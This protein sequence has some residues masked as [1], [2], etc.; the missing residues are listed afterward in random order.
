[1]REGC[2]L[3]NY[4]RQSAQEALDS[5][6]QAFRIAE[7]VLL[8]A[9]V[10]LDA[11]YVSHALEPVQVPAQ[12]TVDAYLPRYAPAQRLDTANVSSWGNVVSQ[13]MFRRHRSAI[14]D[15][16]AQ[17]L[18]VATDADREWAAA[19]GRS[20]GIVERYRCD[21]ARAVVVS[22][23]E[24]VPAFQKTA[25]VSPPTSSITTDHPPTARL[26]MTT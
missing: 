25:T 23:A 26:L 12:E 6:I 4:F 10:N 11:F 16:F 17:A 14:E 18:A 3:G 7:R 5:V 9:M 19:T 8:P 13:D 21:G 22:S 24:V 1:M 2:G 15:A 20:H